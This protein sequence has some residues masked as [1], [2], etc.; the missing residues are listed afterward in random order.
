MLAS[1]DRYNDSIHLNSNEV[2]L[3]D[4][5]AA[6]DR[7]ARLRY[8][9]QVGTDRKSTDRQQELY[10]QAFVRRRRNTVVAMILMIPSGVL[11]GF[12]AA[13]S[14]EGGVILGI[15]TAAWWFLALAVLCSSIVVAALN[16]RCPACNTSFRIY[17]NPQQ[18]E[19]CGAELQ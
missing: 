11:V 18:C 6:V 2:A 15:P 19:A 8:T 1:A 16:W 4:E 13:A 3:V 12:G 17:S 14:V 10:K 7:R 9:V 5:I